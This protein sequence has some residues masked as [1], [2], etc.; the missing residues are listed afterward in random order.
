M[1][2]IIVIAIIAIL[3]IFAVNTLYKNSKSG[4]GCGCGCSGCD[5]E[6]EL[7]NKK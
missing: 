7:M 3:V 5:V 1:G 2:D 4:G 6:K